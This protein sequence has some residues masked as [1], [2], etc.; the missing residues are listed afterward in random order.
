M[1]AAYRKE[2]I[3][4]MRFDSMEY[5]DMNAKQMFETVKAKLCD[6]GRTYFF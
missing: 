2:Q 6:G 1:N 5:D 4:S 3:V